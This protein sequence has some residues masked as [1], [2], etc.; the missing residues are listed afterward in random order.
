[1]SKWDQSKRYEF[2]LQWQNVEETVGDG[3]PQ[4]RLWCPPNEWVPLGI[5]QCLAGEEWHTLV[6]EGEIVDEQVHYQRF[7]IDHQ[8]HTLTRIC[9]YEPSTDPDKLAVA[10]QLDGNLEESPYDVV[11]DKVCLRWS[12]GD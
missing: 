7:V 11:V 10:I 8:S 12:Q 6:L 2:A 5:S 3:A 9:E 4:W 1:M